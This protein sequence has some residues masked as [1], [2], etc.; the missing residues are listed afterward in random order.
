MV[1]CGP[2]GRSGIARLGE[3]ALLAALEAEAAGLL[4]VL[5]PQPARVTLSAN[6]HRLTTTGIFFISRIVRN[7]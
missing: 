4:S 3:A 1:M 6:A 5:V 2:V 7:G